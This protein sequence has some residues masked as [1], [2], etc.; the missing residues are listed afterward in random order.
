MDGCG[1]GVKRRGEA[2]AQA[3]CHAEEQLGP[4]GGRATMNYT[5]L[6]FYYT[7]RGRV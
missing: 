4:G 5:T 1:P 6:L 3:A 2:A 7:Y